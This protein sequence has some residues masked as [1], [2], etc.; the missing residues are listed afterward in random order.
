[1]SYDYLRVRRIAMD[2]VT[3]ARSDAVRA[4]RLR[5]HLSK[6][7]GVVPPDYESAREIGK[8]GL[9]KLGQ[10]LPENGDHASALEYFLS[11]RL[12]GRMGSNVGGMDAAPSLPRGS[13]LDKYLNS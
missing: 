11:G 4:E 10:E 9:E 6:V 1:M 5:S 12:A 7:I 2:A 13:F 8:Y 3:T